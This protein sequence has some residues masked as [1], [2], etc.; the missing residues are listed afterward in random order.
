MIPSK[1]FKQD[2]NLLNVLDWE[3][4]PGN[5]S[6]KDL[7][8]YFVVNT[9]EDEPRIYL[10]KKDSDGVEEF[11]EISMPHALVESFVDFVG[12]RKVIY[13]IEADVRSHIN[14]HLI[15]QDKN[16]IEKIC[17]EWDKEC[18]MKKKFTEMYS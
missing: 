14:K 7:S 13:A 18:L 17:H 10:V 1:H 12:H 11:S 8:Y 2:E 4:T 15:S 6:G 16:D 3:L 9:L 5:T